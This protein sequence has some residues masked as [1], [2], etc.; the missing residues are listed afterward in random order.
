MC[1]Y[2]L[3]DAGGARRCWCGSITVYVWHWCLLPIWLCDDLISNR[4]R[5]IGMEV[6]RRLSFTPLH[7]SLSVVQGAVANG[8]AKFETQKISP[9]KPLRFFSSRSKPSTPLLPV[10][11]PKVTKSYQ[12]ETLCFFRSCSKPSTPLLP[13]SQGNV[14]NKKATLSKPLASSA[15]TTSPPTLSSQS[16]H[17][18]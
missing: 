6:Q 17:R 1:L 3:M 10:K 2:Q 8:R 16:R 11:A 15:V 18:R 4:H 7:L 9:E 14:G 13:C 5:P 12:E